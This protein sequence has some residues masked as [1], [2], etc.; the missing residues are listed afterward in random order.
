MEKVL[1]VSRSFEEADRAD[2]DYY[3]GLTPLKRL[4][5]LLEL[6]KR[7]PQTDASTPP[8]F[9]RVCKIIKRSPG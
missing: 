5:I 8:R 4:E 7:W 2:K 9:Q 1:N 3:H 6:N